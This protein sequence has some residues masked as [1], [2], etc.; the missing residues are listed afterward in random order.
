[1]IPRGFVGVIAVLS[2]QRIA[3]A[4]SQNTHTMFVSSS[5]TFIVLALPFA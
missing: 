4:H 2:E 3:A 5:S 1:M